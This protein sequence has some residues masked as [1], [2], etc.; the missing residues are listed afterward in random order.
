MH[1]LIVLL[2]LA[3]PFTSLV[4]QQFGGH[5]PS[6]KWRQVNT[7]SSRVIFPLGLDSQAKRV[8]GLVSTLEKYTYPSIGQRHRKINIVLQPATTIANAYVMLGPF[9]SEFQLTPQQNSFELGSIPWVDNLAI[10]EFRHIQQYNNFNRGLSKAFSILFGQEGQALANA[11]TIPDW[12]FE[13]DA[14]YQE[15]KVSQQGRGRL[16]FFFNDYQSL[17]AAGK[18]YSWM[19]LRNG[20]FRDFVPDHYR[21]GYMLTAY[22]YEKY[23]NEFWKKVSGD[24]AD[25]R[26]LFYPWQKAVKQYSGVAYPQFRK[27]ALEHFRSQVKNTDDRS[28][29]TK[30]FMADQEYPYWLDSSRVVYMESSY[31]QRPRF[32]IE[33]NGNK[34]EL[35]IRDISLD[36]HFSHRN[37]KIVYAAYRPDLRWT[38]RDYSDI[39]LLDV[40][41][42]KQFTL[43]RRERYFAPDISADGLQVAAVHVD[44]KGNSEL[45][46]LNVADG[47]VSKVVPNPDKLFYTY[48]KYYNDRQLVS[49]VRNRE[50]K[51]SLAIIDIETGA[52]RYI[53]PFS[54]N[55][56]GFPWVEDGRIYFTASYAKKDVLCYWQDGQ[57]YV[58]GQPQ[59]V[60]GSYQL[61]S[62]KG[63]YVWT[64]FTA[65]GYRL[66]YDSQRNGLFAETGKLADNSTF[67]IQKI[68]TDTSNLLSRIPPREFA[69]TR[70]PKSTGLFNFHS[71]RPYISDPDYSFSFVSENIL[72]TLQSE[73]SFNY[74][75]NEEYKQFGFSA[76]YGGW[77]PLLKLG[78]NY[79]V[80]RSAAVRNSDR[81]ALWNEAEA[82]AGFTVPLSFTTGRSLADLSFGSDYVHNK[83]YFKGYYKDSFDN[84]SFGYINNTIS[85]TN[86]VQQARMHIY[87]RWAQTLLLNYKTAVTKFDA[88]QVLVS[89]NLYLPGFFRTHNIVLQAAIHRRDTLRQVIFSNSFPFSRGYATANFHRMWKMGGNYHMPLVYPDWGF[90][91]LVYFQR[92]RSNVFYDFT[93]IHEYNTIRRLVTV[94]FRSWGAEIFFDT[95]WWNQLPVS[96]GFRYSRLLNPDIVDGRGPN[97]WEFILP[98]NLLSR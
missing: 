28:V 33:E 36:H 58:A 4:A 90:A 67:D 35:R 64:K 38:W 61:N 79:T 55:V 21:L 30:H 46:L 92:I 53:L 9:R 11:L 29:T 6:V 80:D 13:G 89:G 2:F 27:D 78:L 82:R 12:F 50:G 19:K 95:K 62:L 91:S 22:G 5:P 18:N 32:V 72:N 48:P 15:T 31:K 14:V 96:F 49:A 75:R 56:I 94:D 97:Q 76:I 34:R 68:E 74:N 52:N 81:L 44:G 25:F 93:R 42:N 54:L 20:S 65:S 69:V 70:Y 88:S 41:T 73:F 47:T 37:G 98:I 7:D 59:D 26:G 83:R 71:R 85:F 60:T 84:R 86:Q 51:M 24:A 40:A 10:H 43:T 8:A 66:M 57:L 1:R 63:K 39:K 23:G 45:R 16:P 87:P 17:W 3:C 77:F